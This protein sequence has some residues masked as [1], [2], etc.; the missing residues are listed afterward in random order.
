MDEGYNGKEVFEILEKMTPEE[1][2]DYVCFTWWSIEDV[3]R[4]IKDWKDLYGK[5]RKGVER[6]DALDHDDKM[7]ILDEALSDA[8][9]GAGI[10]EINDLLWDIVCNTAKGKRSIEQ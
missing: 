9:D 4:H 3:D 5:D 8:N 2:Q 6:L 1:R 7:A 10:S